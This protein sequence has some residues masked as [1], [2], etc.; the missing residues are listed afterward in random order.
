MSQINEKAVLE[1]IEI[2]RTKVKLLERKQKIECPCCG[3]EVGS[4]EEKLYI[5]HAL[6]LQRWFNLYLENKKP[7][8]HY[9]D[10][11][12]YISDNYNVNTTDYGKLYAFG[13]ISPMPKEKGIDVNSNGMWCI[14]QRGIAFLQGK[15]KIPKY[16]LR[17]NDGH[18]FERSDEEI[19]IFDINSFFRYDEIFDKNLLKTKKNKLKLKK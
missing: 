12:R 15:Y 5:G 7:Y 18:I 2:F 3:T 16:I 8:H 14:T 9:R 13:L 11:C 17:M 10:V 19:S 1:Y 4:R 6:L